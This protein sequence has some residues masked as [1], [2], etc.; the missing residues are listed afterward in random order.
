MRFFTFSKKSIF[1][2]ILVPIWF[3][4]ATQN[5]PKTKTKR[6]QEASK[7]VINFGI[8]FVTIW[9]QFWEPSWS[10]VGSLIGQK[11]AQFLDDFLNVSRIG[12]PQ[13]GGPGPSAQAP[14]LGHHK[15]CPLDSK[16]GVQYPKGTV[17]RNW[18]LV[19]K[20]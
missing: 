9:S 6:V 12:S 17:N 8:D 5:P 13:F 11:I 14:R 15:W 16:T 19:P 10:N 2:P 4:F 7:K 20:L 1:H 3:H 18:E